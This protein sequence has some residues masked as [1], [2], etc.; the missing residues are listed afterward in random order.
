MSCEDKVCLHKN[1]HFCTNL[2]ALG[3]VGCIP[4]QALGGRAGKC[5]LWA[6][7]RLDPWEVRD[8]SWALQDGNVD[9]AGRREKGLFGRGNH[10]GGR[11]GICV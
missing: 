9:M 3:I 5:S 4:E 11:L 6:G 10:M 7:Q 8:L 1:I 2:S